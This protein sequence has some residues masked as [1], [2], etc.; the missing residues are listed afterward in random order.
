MHIALAGIV[1]C[2][3]RYIKLSLDP[4]VNPAEPLVAVLLSAVQWKNSGS[5]RDQLCV[6]KHAVAIDGGAFCE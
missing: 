4:T 6:V 2:Y 1:S 5:Q 3:Q